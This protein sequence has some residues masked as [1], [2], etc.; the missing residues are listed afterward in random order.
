VLRRIET[1]SSKTSQDL[2][3][4]VLMIKYTLQT[5]QIYLRRRKE[6]LKRG[7]SR[8]ESKST[9]FL[10]PLTRLSPK[11]PEMARKHDLTDG[12]G[13]DA[14]ASSSRGKRQ[15]TSPLPNS[16]PPAEQEPEEDASGDEGVTLSLMG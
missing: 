16:T 3:N 10:R 15:R 9:F 14:G 7:E 6:R 11:S 1:K 4:R 5:L 12:E 2:L 13:S 8:R